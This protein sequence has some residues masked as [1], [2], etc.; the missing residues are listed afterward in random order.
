MIG[1]P[2]P[3]VRAYVIRTYNV[4][5]RPYCDCRR[6][7]LGSMDWTEVPI[8]VLGG[9][10]DRFLALPVQPRSQ[11]ASPTAG[12]KNDVTQGAE[13]VLGFFEDRKPVVLGTLGN[14]AGGLSSSPAPQTQ[15]GGNLAPQIDPNTTAWK[16]D[17]A[18]VLMRGGDIGLVPKPGQNLSAELDGGVLRVASNG[19]ASDAAVVAT[20]LEVALAPLYAKIA[21]QESQ[22][23]LL[24]LAVAA[25]AAPAPSPVPPYVADAVEPL[26]A[27]EVASK[28]LKVSREV[29]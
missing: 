10:A 24:T 5:G 8:M 27:D 12:A 11:N 25:A 14:V 26:R 15:A 19:E 17:G 13:V 6:P 16:W 9:G 22:I 1:S 4:N 3:L 29:G 23:A 18:T 21:A 28:V 7:G 20:A 2:L